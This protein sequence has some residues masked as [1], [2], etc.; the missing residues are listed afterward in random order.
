MAGKTGIA[1]LF[2][3]LVALSP[4][5]HAADYANESFGDGTCDETWGPIFGNPEIPSA[6][7]ASNAPTGAA[8]PGNNGYVGQSRCMMQKEIMSH[9]GITFFEITSITAS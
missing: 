4:L 6:T 1:V 9:S 7:D 8:P 3:V 5:V 2:I